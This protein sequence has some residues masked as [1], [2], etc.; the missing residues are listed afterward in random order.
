MQT[1]SQTTDNR[2]RHRASLH[3]GVV[4][5]C[6]CD[7]NESRREWLPSRT[8]GVGAAEAEAEMAE[9]AK[10]GRWIVPED[11]VG[12]ERSLG[13]IGVLALL[14][15]GCLLGGCLLCPVG[16]AQAR[17][18]KGGGDGEQRQS[19]GRGAV[20]EAGGVRA[21]PSE[22]AA[23]RAHMPSMHGCRLAASGC[24]CDSADSDRRVSLLA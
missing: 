17:T 16:H 18:A 2:H 19:R 21:S 22:H 8:Q 12:G 14:L 10:A 11:D 20:E 6:L 1:H 4:L 3:C 5:L 23:T 24:A 9:R 7:C 15:D 13:G